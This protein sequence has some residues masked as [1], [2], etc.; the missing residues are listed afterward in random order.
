MK[1]RF[2]K[3][4]DI[5]Y[6]SLTNL[7]RYADPDEPRFPIQYWMRGKDVIAYLGLWETINNNL[8]NRVEFDTVKADLLHLVILNNLEISNSE[9]IKLGLKQ[10]E[11]L[12]RL[13]ESARKQIETLKNSKSI[14]ELKLLE[15]KTYILN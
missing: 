14:E 6:I 12:I 3:V 9:F 10:S 5:E 1:S 13:N 15:N 11:R 2:T 8:F 4:G 7:A